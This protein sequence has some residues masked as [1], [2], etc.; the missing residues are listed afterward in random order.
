[1]PTDGQQQQH[2]ITLPHITS[3]EFVVAVSNVASELF[4]RNMQLLSHR[5]LSVKVPTSVEETVSETALK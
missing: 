4:D 2:N 5:L 1:M 3:E